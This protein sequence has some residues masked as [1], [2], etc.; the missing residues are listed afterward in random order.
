MAVSSP[1]QLG[2]RPAGC[3]SETPAGRACLQPVT[4]G[5]PEGGASVS[6]GEGGGGLLE[7]RSWRMSPSSSSSVSPTHPSSAAGGCR[8][9]HTHAHTHTRALALAR[10]RARALTLAGAGAGGGPG[11]RG[12]PSQGAAACARARAHTHTAPNNQVKFPIPPT[13]TP[14]LTRDRVSE[15][16]ESIHIR[17]SPGRISA[18]TWTSLR[19]CT[20]S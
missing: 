6:G 4:P 16:S 14:A 12:R 19:A 1:A 15:T 13:P 18:P 10:V 20:A 11:R 8:L 17:V 5:R 7:F 2:S 3:R 9:A